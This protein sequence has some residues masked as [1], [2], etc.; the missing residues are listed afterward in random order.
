MYKKGKISLQ[1]LSKM[2]SLCVC[3]ETTNGREL[4]KRE[5]ENARKEY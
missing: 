1:Y 4:I 3:M 2:I 5:G